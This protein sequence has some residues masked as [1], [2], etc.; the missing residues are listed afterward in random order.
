MTDANEAIAECLRICDMF[1]DE[2][3]R[4]AEDTVMMDPL[5]SRLRNRR[6]GDAVEPL[7]ATDIALCERLEIEGCIHSSMHHAAKNIG[8]AIR[9]RFNLPKQDEWE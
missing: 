9:E 1:A 4:M 2:N 8:D 5:L 7:D 3:L 6:R